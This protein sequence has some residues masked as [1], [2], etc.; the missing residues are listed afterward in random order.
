[1]KSITDDSLSR[2]DKKELKRELGISGKRLRALQKR[3]RRALANKTQI[4]KKTLS[5]IDSSVKNFAKGI[6]GDPIDIEKI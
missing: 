4:S 5:M 3:A 6:V 1:M 2:R